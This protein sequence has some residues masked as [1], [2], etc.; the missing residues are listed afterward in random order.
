MSTYSKRSAK[1]ISNLSIVGEDGSSMHVRCMLRQDMA[2][3]HDRKVGIW[4]R[5]LLTLT[6]AHRHTHH[7]DLVDFDLNLE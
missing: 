3:A 5:A 2:N 1:Q 6:Q 7:P 4:L